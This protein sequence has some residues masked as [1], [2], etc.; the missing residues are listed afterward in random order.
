M[1]V[2][3]AAVR[4]EGDRGEFCGA[5]HGPILHY[6]EESGALELL[7]SESPPLGV[8]EDEVFAARSVSFRTGD[9]FLLMTD[10]LTEV[11]ASNGSMLGQAPIERLLCSL[12]D[13]PLSEIY[14]GIMAAVQSY[15]RQSDDQTLLLM[16]VR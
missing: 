16:R 15:G 13:R 14:A 9:V 7:E 12:A 2:T 8:V 4:L 3:G 10:G 1:F 5:G 6:S 11:F